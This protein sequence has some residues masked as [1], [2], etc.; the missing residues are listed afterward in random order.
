M[1]KISYVDGSYCNYEN[2][3]ININDRGY[4][5]GDAV[6]EVVMFN[7]NIFFDFDE[8]I[9]RLFKS[10]ISIDIT[11]KFS[12]KSLKIIINKLIKI[13]K[14]SYG[15]VYIQVSRGIAP[16]NHSYN[17][18]KLKPVLIISITEKKFDYHNK[19]KRVN[20]ITLS[21]N[22]WD[23]PDIKTT[24]LL[25]NI[26][27]KTKAEQNNAFESIFLDEKDFIT[28]GSS[29]NIW[30][31]NYQNELITRGLDGKILSGITRSTIAKYANKNKIKLVERK[32]SKNELYNAKEVFLTS[33]SSF[34]TQIIKVDDYLINN[35][36][37][38]NVSVNLRETYIKANEKC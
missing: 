34:V 28:E 2:S 37:V 31:L 12:I 21:D 35:G 6:Y 36:L 25:P 30:I 23:R 24:Q 33:A 1:P 5:F 32:F 10:L 16:R 14:A 38:G 17:N 29:S 9:E 11:L 26:L 19:I 13:N 4:H 27:A 15:S 18:L 22:R 8:H 20:A 7:Q 3:K